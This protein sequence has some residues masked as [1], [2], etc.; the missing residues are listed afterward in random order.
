M[1]RQ[2]MFKEG[3]SPQKTL[4]YIDYIQHIDIE[5][6]KTGRGYDVVESDFNVGLFI[7]HEIQ[8]L[9]KAVSEITDQIYK[10]RDS[11]PGRP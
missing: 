7:C 6:S 5:P 3:P 8:Q 9:R 11:I 1:K 4:E 2:D 10:Y